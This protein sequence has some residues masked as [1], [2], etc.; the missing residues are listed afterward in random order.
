MVWRRFQSIPHVSCNQVKGAM[1]AYPR[2]DLPHRA[3]EEARVSV[4]VCACVCVCVCV[5]VRVC[6]CD[7]TSWL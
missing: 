6:M 3:I 4:C 2:I 7:T 1:Y 5:C